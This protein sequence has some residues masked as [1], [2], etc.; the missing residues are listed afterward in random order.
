[1]LIPYAPL[2]VNRG[3]VVVYAVQTN[4][5]GLKTE[6]ATYKWEAQ[7]YDVLNFFFFLN[8]DLGTDMRVNILAFLMTWLSGLMDQR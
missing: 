6:H 2:E 5:C 4:H 7:F 1:M 8:W 3:V